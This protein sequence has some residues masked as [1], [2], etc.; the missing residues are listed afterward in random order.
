V[1]YFVRPEDELL[2]KPVE[3]PLLERLG[4]KGEGEGEAVTAGEWVKARVAKNV[5]KA[6]GS[7]ETGEQE[8]IK[9][10]KAKW[11]D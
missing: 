4:L 3:S 9:G 8:I 5:N 10:V 2:L 11:Y 6:G 7:K 1:L